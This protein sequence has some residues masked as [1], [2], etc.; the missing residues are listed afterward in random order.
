M[1]DSPKKKYERPVFPDFPSAVAQRCG[2]VDAVAASN[3]MRNAKPSKAKPAKNEVRTVLSSGDA[4]REG[5]VVPV[6]AAPSRKSSKPKTPKKTRVAKAKEALATAEKK[7]SAKGGRPS[8]G[9][10]WK[11]LGLSKATY[12]RRIKDQEGPKP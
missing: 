10:P 4:S 3:Y 9:E 7:S 5:V 1:S 12:Y 11:A 6:T 2:G 8:K